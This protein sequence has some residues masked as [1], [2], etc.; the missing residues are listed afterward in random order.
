MKNVTLK[1][2]GDK[3]IIEVDL[4]KEFGLSA[5]GK[6]L[7]IASTEGNV[8]LEGGAKLGLNVYRGK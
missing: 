1:Q 3:L 5:S 6:S 4:K 7:L 8:T 2:T